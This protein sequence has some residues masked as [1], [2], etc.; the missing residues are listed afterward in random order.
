MNKEVERCINVVADSIKSKAKD[1]SNDISGVSSIKIVA[2][3]VNGEIL[4]FNVVKN[5]YCFDY[6]GRPPERID[7]KNFLDDL[8]SD[9]NE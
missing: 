2:E 7:L 9:N 4:N 6:I 1:I 3:I 8:E 5:Y